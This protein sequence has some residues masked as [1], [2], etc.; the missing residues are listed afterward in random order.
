MGNEQAHN[1]EPDVA[2]CQPC[3]PGAEDFD[4]NGVQ[5]DIEAKLEQIKAG[6]IAKGIMNA[7]DELAI[8]G[9]Y[10]EELAGRCGTTSS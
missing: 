5:S 2:R 4:L 8:P 6:L 1:F 7:A 3:H 9:T 10:P